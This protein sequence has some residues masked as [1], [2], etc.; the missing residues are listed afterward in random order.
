V[1]WVKTVQAGV[2]VCKGIHRD[3][4]WD[5]LDMRVS[6]RGARPAALAP[7]C[8]RTGLLS[9]QMRWER[10]RA[11]TRITPFARHMRMPLPHTPLRRSQEPHGWRGPSAGPAASQSPGAQRG[12]QHPRAGQGVSERWLL[13]TRLPTGRSPLASGLRPAQNGRLDGPQMGARAHAANPLRPPY[14][15]GK[16]GR[17]RDMCGRGASPR[18]DKDAPAR[19]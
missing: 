7:R 15:C 14:W 11:Q 1:T 18:L 12:C 9:T 17:A 8:Q 19:R 2:K 10:A 13:V 3:Q 5:G 4:P 16:N 6:P